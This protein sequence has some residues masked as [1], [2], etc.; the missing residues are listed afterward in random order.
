MV[1][2]TQLNPYFEFA[3]RLKEI[4]GLQLFS[5]D[6]ITC[7]M[8]LTTWQEGTSLQEMLHNVEDVLIDAKAANKN[9]VKVD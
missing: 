8:G 6:P 3:N 1:L 4:I 9:T 7:S 5:S 2:P